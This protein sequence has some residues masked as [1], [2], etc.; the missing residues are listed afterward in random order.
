MILNTLLDEE[1]SWLHG[2]NIEF[3]PRPARPLLSGP[4][5]RSLANVDVM[6]NLKLH[7][8]KV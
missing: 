6:A 4:S 1:S 8:L 2:Q 3:A 7:L 5:A